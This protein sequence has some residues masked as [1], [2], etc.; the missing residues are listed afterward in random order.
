MYFL[1]NSQGRR[2]PQVAQFG[3][4]RKSVVAAGICD[5]KG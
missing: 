5:N 1:R 4:D 2:Q 3:K